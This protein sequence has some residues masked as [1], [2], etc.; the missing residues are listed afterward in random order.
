MTR[1]P[2]SCTFSEMLPNTTS[3]TGHPFFVVAHALAA[4]SA[5]PVVTT[6]MAQLG[7]KPLFENWS[8]DAAVA[9]AAKGGIALAKT[10]DLLLL[11]LSIRESGNLQEDARN[12]YNQLL[13]LVRAEGYPHLLRAWNYMARINEGEGDCERYK[14]FCAGRHEA[15]TT[16]QVKEGE[17]PAASALGHNTPELVVYLLAAKR[18][19]IHVENPNQQSAYA[20]PRIYGP[21][22]PSFARA[23]ACPDLGLTFISGTASITG[24]ATRHHDDVVAQLGLTLDNIET[25][26]AHIGAKEQLSLGRPLLKVYIRQPEDYPLIRQQLEARLPLAE[27]I[28]L[29]ADICRADLLLE[30]EAVYRHD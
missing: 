5:V 3:G 8:V 4:K 12:A 20:Y 2:L 6:G 9:C 7:P 25:L 18:P 21:K 14:Q 19:G 29:Q 11:S 30:I 24:H 10:A 26:V 16:Q 23:T 28:Y 1:N 17:Y 13:P 15:F 27:C 22:S